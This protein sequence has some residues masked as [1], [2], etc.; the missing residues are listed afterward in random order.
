MTLLQTVVDSMAK[1]GLSL[2]EALWVHEPAETTAEEA[3]KT[4]M[5]LAR[6]DSGLPDLD[7]ER[8][9]TA[10]CYLQAHMDEFT[11]AI[12]KTK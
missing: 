3:I 5:R 4:V 11:E 2:A 9:F 7:R 10:Y 1:D 6:K 12:K 8:L